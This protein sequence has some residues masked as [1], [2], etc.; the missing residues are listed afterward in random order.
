[1]RKLTEQEFLDKVRNAHGGRVKV[2][3]AYI[4]TRL[5]IDLQC[6][7]CDLK[8]SAVAASIVRGIGCPGCGAMKAKDTIKHPD[9]A[10]RFRKRLASRHGGTTVTT[11][12]YLSMGERIGASCSTCRRVWNTTPAR[13]LVHGCLVCGHKRTGSKTR[14]SHETFLAEMRA[15]H[16][17]RIRALGRYSTGKA[18]IAVACQR[19]G[20]EWQPVAGRLIRTNGRGCPRCP[21]SKAEVRIA[22]IFRCAGVEF[23]QQHSFPDL[24]VHKR[25]KLT[26]DFAV[27]TEEG[28]S[29]LVEYDGYH[30]FYPIKARGG[31]A[32]L[33]Q[34]RNN[35]QIKDSYCSLNG[36]PLIRLKMT[37]I[38]EITLDRLLQ[39]A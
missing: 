26:F 16:G 17:D 37:P 11:T 39:T 12:P 19:C 25:G 3:S 31:E 5:K 10:A 28:L 4:H 9:A 2:T 1:M 35:D 21:L 20:H 14:K 36:I 6:S 8:W 29:H 23:T 34:Q 24:N 15:M 18:R 7:A 22:E 30:H 32:R 38:R 27:W 33:V 13:L